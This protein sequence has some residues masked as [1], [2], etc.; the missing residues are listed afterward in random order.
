[1]KKYLKFVAAMLIGA[2]SVTSSAQS[3]TDPYLFNHLGV[4]V[5]VGT[6]GVGFEFSTPVSH[7]VT[8]RAGATFMPKITFNTDGGNYLS[9]IN[10]EK[11][12]LDPRYAGIT[13][14]IMKQHTKLNEFQNKKDKIKYILSRY[15]NYYQLKIDKIKTKLLHKK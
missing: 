15:T 14:K 1:M 5:N 9:S 8:M 4:D 3:L 12:Y 6:L 7:F 11:I 13:D 2:A 10:I